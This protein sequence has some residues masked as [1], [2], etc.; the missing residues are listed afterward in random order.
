MF[1]RYLLTGATGFLGSWV[2]QELIAGS[3]P[4]RALVLPGD[5]LSALLP[6]R[7]EQTSG[8]VTDPASLTAFFRDAGPDTCLIHCAGMISIA[9]RPGAKI[10]HVNVEGTGAL[11]HQCFKHQVGRMVYVSSVHALPEKPPGQII[12]EEADFSPEK[13]TGA[14]AQ[15]KAMATRLVLAAAGEGLN[16]SVVFPSGLIGP[17][18]RQE[19]SFTVM[20]KRFLGGQ[21]P[22]AVRGGYDFAD[23]RD[24]ARGI[25]ACA[26][27]G[28]RGEGYILSGGYMT[29]Q[30]MLSAMGKA[31]GVQHR[32]ICLPLALARWVAP[33][34]ER[35]T[36]RQGKPLFFTPYSVGVLASNGLFSHAKAAQELGYTVRG[37]EDTLG[38]MARWIM[39]EG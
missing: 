1:D 13:V 21:L 30:A 10:Y 32:P 39:Q 33:H 35:K 26:A 17:G 36:L 34:F 6:Q 28:R 3:V 29:I 8:D 12:T 25:L 19:D 2:V 24:V 37:A 23:V 4:V 9:S 38:D 20:A 22:F 7:V 15:T 16:A 27:R 5:P 31:A 11:V 18:S 14:Y